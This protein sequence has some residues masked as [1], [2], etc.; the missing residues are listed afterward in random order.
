[1][2]HIWVK[3][4]GPGRRVPTERRGVYFD[5]K[6]AHHVRLTPFIQRRLDEKDLVKADP[7]PEPKPADGAATV[8]AAMTAH[9]E[10]MAAVADALAAHAEDGAEHVEQ[11]A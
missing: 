8:E 3:V 1:M 7:P 11:G 2:T 6:E 9:P 4:A 10:V 5:P